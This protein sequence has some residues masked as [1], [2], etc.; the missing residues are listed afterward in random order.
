[1]RPRNTILYRGADIMALLL[2]GNSEYRVGAVYFEFVT[3]PTTFAVTYTWTSVYTGR[4]RV[5]QKGIQGQ[6]ADV[7]EAALVLLRLEVQVPVVGTEG[8][9]VD[10]RVTVTASAHDPDLVGRAFTIRD[11]AHKTHATAR[12]VQVQEV[13]S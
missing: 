11:L 13:T 5:Q 10:D 3:S 9:M 6:D 4:C 12:R 2:G 8:L 7:G 1:M